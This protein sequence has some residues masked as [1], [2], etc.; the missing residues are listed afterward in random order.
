MLAV[1]EV[2]ERPPGPLLMR[3]NSSRGLN[4][5]FDHDHTSLQQGPEDDFE[6]DIGFENFQRA[7]KDAI[8]LANYDIS[9]YDTAWVA[10]IPKVFAGENLVPHFPEALQWVERNQK[11]DGSWGELQPINKFDEYFS[12]LSCLIALKTWNVGHESVAKG[13][14][15]LQEKLVTLGDKELKYVSH[16]AKVAFAAMLE[17]AE[18]LG[19][20]LSSPSSSSPLPCVENLRSYRTKVLER[21]KTFADVIADCPKKLLSFPE[22]LEPVLD[23]EGIGDLQFEDGSI[24]SSPAAT[25]C[26]IMRTKD[27]KAMNYL[28]SL[29]G[30][31]NDAVPCMYPT[32]LSEIL[33][34]VDHLERLNIDRYFSAEIRELLDILHRQSELHGY[35]HDDLPSEDIETQAM[36]FRALREYQY[37]VTPET[38][39]L[40]GI[41]SGQIGELGAR[42]ML[43]L[44]RASELIFPGELL[45][46]YTR[47]V[48]TVSLRNILNT[49][50]DPALKKEVEDA[51][52]SPHFMQFR[53]FESMKYID[54][55]DSS[56]EANETYFEMTFSRLMHKLNPLMVAFAK[57]NFNK[58]QAIYQE[59]LQALTKWDDDHLRNAYNFQRQPLLPAFLA[60]AVGMPDPKLALARSVWTRGSVLVT[61]I[62]DLFDEAT[63]HDGIQGLR[64]FHESIKR[65]DP[66]IVDSCCGPVKTL[67]RLLMSEVDCLCKEA[68]EAQ[69]RDLTPFLRSIWQDVIAEFLTEAEWND[70]GYQPSSEEY[71][72][73]GSISFGLGPITLYTIFCYG[74]HISDEMLD[75]NDYLDAF[76]LVNRY[77][78]LI[79]DLRTHSREVLGMHNSFI[80]VYE[81]EHPK[82]SKQEA[83]AGVQN[84]LKGLAS[85][86]FSQLLNSRYTSQAVRD[87]HLAMIRSLY[88][89]Y[90]EV[91]GYRFTSHELK[92]QIQRFFYKR[93]SCE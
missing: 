10:R 89:M 36:I 31:F 45:L 42:G 78:R 3:L 67:A 6:E 77:G 37:D 12:T 60:G 40:E 14:Q 19:L 41:S 68:S 82:L 27:S 15:Y 51:L 87:V 26:F 33:S 30:R 47:N 8:S 1:A 17:D 70:S 28:T 9:A 4:V 88:L 52:H 21:L 79:N 54:R 63:L 24:F 49:T 43:Q 35:D 61:V 16:G 76:D 64:L 72:R 58:C 86:V 20:S 55:F 75:N 92:K 74:E 85:K 5:V 90:Y 80:S 84:L 50:T 91:D 25:A 66:S 83:Y 32:P 59:E 57:V 39:L 38:F 34:I 93:F 48:T 71:L 22:G 11:D 44:Y 13:E 65:W 62:D 53:P 46:D 2:P 73:T 18:K 69:G 81:R 29:I 56:V 7:V 23:W